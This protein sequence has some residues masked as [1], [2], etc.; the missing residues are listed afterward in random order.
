MKRA[1]RIGA[2][3]AAV[4]TVSA[5]AGCAATEPYE[6]PAVERQVA[7]GAED[8][9][10]DEV[11]AASASLAPCALLDADVA[12]EHGVTAP[13]VAQLFSCAIED[14]VVVTT[15]VPFGQ[16]ERFWQERVDFQGVVAYR[17]PAV[18]ESCD[19]MLPTS[20]GAA[21]VFDQHEYGAPYDCTE[22]DAFAAAAVEKLKSDPESLQRPDGGDG[23]VACD[24]FEEAIGEAPEGMS[25][26]A[27][28]LVS[29]DGLDACGLWADPDDSGFQAVEPQSGLWLNLRAPLA[30]FSSQ[31]GW[32]RHEKVL[33]AGREVMQDSDDRACDLFFDVRPAAEAEGK[34]LA[35][36]VSGPD[37]A[38]AAELM[39]RMVPLLDA[40]TP[41]PA[42]AGGLLFASD[43]PDSPAVGACVDALVQA[44]RE[45]TPFDRPEVPPSPADRLSRGVVDADVLCALAADPVRTRL[46][47]EPKP[48]TVMSDG[49]GGTQIP[50]GAEVCEFVVP[51]H[52]VV[53]RVAASL[54]P[55]AEVRD[56][57]KQ[58]FAGHPAS[59]QANEDEHRSTAWVA[60][61]EP[62]EAGHLIVEV[63]VWP[64][65]DE[66]LFDTSPIDVSPLENFELIAGGV[67][68]AV[69]GG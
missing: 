37:C 55:L 50:R 40:A 58:E 60:F 67:A 35:A 3:M 30:E 38:A 69:L 16:N 63:Q 10:A 14:S 41:A 8:R 32:Q 18:L 39:T 1:L 17:S 65:R 31:G 28:S 22:V 26:R 7:T 47:D 34:V 53:V 43:E 61:G 24:V 6:A 62:D 25:F 2:V 68:A 51:S 42:D 23:I 36:V 20:F 11:R 21:I 27:R 44:E 52:A 12:A 33:V 57:V 45:C 46:G 66:G 19:L 56:T 29:G 49:Q 5:L 15:S 59:V 13:P 9:P 48:V 64:D 54:T 4:I